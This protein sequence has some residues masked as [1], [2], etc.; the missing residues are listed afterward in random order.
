[1][2]V[3][4]YW[5]LVFAI[6]IPGIILLYLLKQK[7]EKNPYSALNLWR[8]AYQNMQASTPWEKFKNNILM[9]LQI[10]ALVL[11][12][13]AGMAPFVR[14]DK[15]NGSNVILCIDNSASMNGIYQGDMTRLERAKEQAKA[16]VDSMKQGSAVTVI[17][18]SHTAQVLLGA[19]SDRNLVRQT[20]EDIPETDTQGT[21]D[22]A[23]SLLKSLTEQWED[24][25]IVGFTDSDVN[26]EGLSSMEIIDCSSSQANASVDYVSHR[27]NE[28]GAVDVMACVTDQG[29]GALEG[30]VELYLGDQ[31]Y[32]VQE[33]RI[34]EGESQIIYFEPI[35]ASRYRSVRAGKSP[36]LRAE[37]TG[38]DGMDGDNSAWEILT[39][40][41]DSR[42]LLVTEK[43]VFLE[44]ALTASKEAEVRVANRLENADSSRYDL[45]VYDGVAPREQPKGVN[46]LFINPPQGVEGVFSINGSRKNITVTARK[47]DVTEY[48]EDFTFGCSKVA[49]LE[50]PSWGQSFL[51]ADG[52]CVGFSGEYQGNTIS[53]LGFDIHNSDLPLQM[54][55]PILIHNLLERCLERG[56]LSEH[57]YAP[58]DTVLWNLSQDCTRVTV[59]GPEGKKQYKGDALSTGCT[60]TMRSGLYHLVCEGGKEDA[61]FQVNFPLEESVMKQGITLSGSKD[62]AHNVR[63]IRGDIPILVPVLLFALAVLVLEWVIYLL[64]GGLRS[65][66]GW[67]KRKTLLLRGLLFACIV[68]AM[69]G[70]SVNT[71]KEKNTTI[72]LLDV[73]D[74]FQNDREQ[75]VEYVKKSLGQMGK[76]DQAGVVAFGADAAVEQ[77]VTQARL[78]QGLETNTVTTATNIE[79]AIQTA[80]ALF[81]ADSGKRLVLLTDG[82][83]NEGTASN[84]AP[85]LQ[86]GK[87]SLRIL[88]L[89]SNVGD[90]VYLSDVT[91]PEKIK[92]GD[93]FEVQVDVES[94]SATQ[95][96]LYLYAGDT[97]KKKETVQLQKGS[98]SFV[99][100]DVRKK[101][102]FVHYRVEIDARKD[103]QQENN[104]YAAYTQ[105][106]SGSR[107]LIVEG[108]EG[109]GKEFQRLLQAA[110]IDCDRI[111]A[112]RAPKTL[113]ALN[114]YRAI[115]LENVYKGDLPKGFLD[116]V[117]SY[118]KD[119]GGGLAAI[120]GDRSFALGGYRDSILEDILPVN[121]ELTGKKEVPQTAMVMV[122]DHSGSML[123]MN[124]EDKLSLAKEAAEVAVD[125]LRDTD[126]AGV[127]S[128]DDHYHWTS[129]L[130]EADDKEEIKNNIRGIA[131]GGG[132]SIYPAVREAYA[133]L[134]KSDAQL[135][136]II[137]L[138][139]G[140]DN[141]KDYSDLITD[142]NKAD[143]TLSTV[144]VGADADG[145]LLAALAQSTQGRYYQTEAGSD[146]PRIFAQEVFLSQGEYLVNRE[147]VPEA[148]G[149]DQLLSGVG[150]KGF[151]VLGGY[152]ATTAKNTAV[153]PLLS[154]EQDPIL[155]YW[156]YGLGRTVAFTSDVTNQWTARY[157]LWEDYPKL[158]KNIAEWLIQ[159][160]DSESLVTVSQEGSKGKVVYETSADT[161]DSEAE[162]VYFDK[163]TKIRQ[164]MDAVAPGVF[165]AELAVSEPGVYD[166]NIRRTADGQVKESKNSVLAMQY[167]VE[168]RFLDSHSTLDTL[169]SQTGGK[170]IDSL[171]GIYE[172]P[173]ERVKSNCDLTLL[174][175]V[176]A[177]LLLFYDIA[178]RRLG[179]SLLPGPIEKAWK[180][181][182]KL[183]MKRGKMP[184]PENRRRR[185]NEEA[186][187]LDTN[188]LLHKKEKREQRY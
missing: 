159:E 121:M 46:Q 60:D 23:A 72:F 88:Q 70:I 34:K 133:A 183:Q 119:Y 32:D 157:A 82:K 111:L 45:I 71:Q 108:E 40:N 55:F 85:A 3:I 156:R 175:L 37:W 107:V 138:T 109:E 103:T 54:E 79:Q 28:D 125:N 129:K 87:V 47:G 74:S 173:L 165:E 154:E 176:C 26:G 62:V 91:V 12:I 181:R 94:T 112:Q 164:K 95:A 118:V 15:E 78:F 22:T 75:A 84:M 105:A 149:A 14:A 98:N 61:W 27:V 180:G 122:I 169:V 166:L 69:L 4:R 93:R 130:T 97:L 36:V 100:Q 162:V 148:A 52:E 25:Q 151:P 13:F 66:R 33:A 177:I 143:I 59:S 65:Q 179:I 57:S 113:N 76:K 126:L 150:Q 9:Y 120:G 140:E 158:W 8:E 160:E 63:E 188:T 102:G 92:V 115:F 10:L 18:V 147:F 178:W 99:F 184:R 110:N 7:V 86:M 31:L 139:D 152:V 123:G 96:E 20:V 19:S 127:L 49:T 161:R 117:G 56:P 11:L 51:E 81:P 80:L 104:T 146:L 182:K 83:E 89:G 2:G 185:R 39:G 58:G 41:A 142:I 42:I 5:P 174:F 172:E 168:Y 155:S 135:K 50:L 35:T 29:S 128:F 134:K 136:H 170:Y 132:T 64:A 106:S 38:R 67:K 124:G 186:E 43:N 16:Y 68:C 141:Y 53:V 114:G 77:F 44:R 17:S 131:M 21:L 167:S 144:A 163:D 90:E 30:E 48:L 153:T 187:L 101:E 73:S 116:Q 171:D 1:M 24:Y 137:L 6:G 145:K